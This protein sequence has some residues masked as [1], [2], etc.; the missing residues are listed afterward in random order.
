M[1]QKNTVIY[2]SIYLS[3]C[4]YLITSQHY[5]LGEGAVTAKVPASGTRVMPVVSVPKIT[6]ILDLPTLLA[7]LDYQRGLVARGD[8]ETFLF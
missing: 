5:S 3:I 4:Q 2:L 8:V 7:M 1:L 6:E